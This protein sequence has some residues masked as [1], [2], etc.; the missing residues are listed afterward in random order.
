[1]V[2]IENQEGLVDGYCVG[3]LMGVAL[4]V[5]IGISVGKTNDD[6]VGC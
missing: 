6:K 3:S 4:G 1:M 5:I 2:K